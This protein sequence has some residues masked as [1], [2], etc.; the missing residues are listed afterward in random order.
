MAD[1]DQTT[2]PPPEET[3]AEDQA[4]ARSDADDELR[5]EGE[6]H[7]P[8][9]E[10]AL[11]SALKEEVERE[12]DAAFAD[13][14]ATETDPAAVAEPEAAATPAEAQS[15]PA[16]QAEPGEAAT[17]AE[18]ASPP[19]GQ[20]EPVEPE[21]AETPSPSAA[22]ADVDNQAATTGLAFDD[23]EA[24]DLEAKKVLM[25]EVSELEAAAERQEAQT[26]PEGEPAEGPAGEPAAETVAQAPA[27]EAVNED[28][29][30]EGESPAS[31]VS[32]EGQTPSEAAETAEASQPAEAEDQPSEQPADEETPQ[33]EEAPAGEGEKSPK[34][35]QAAI[36]AVAETEREALLEEQPAEGRKE[37]DDEKDSEEEGESAETEGGL[38]SLLLLPLQALVF[39]LGLMDR[40]FRGV[41]PDTRDLLGK[42][43]LACLVT[44]VLI[45]IFAL[46]RPLFS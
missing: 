45:F 28:Q 31:E 41:G 4:T 23:D 27:E 13:D 10:E 44:A 5:G 9:A 26:A 8:P 22:V 17:P 15:P 18:A 21:E 2:S 34:P 7:A 16:K 30:A 46:L 11:D 3:P 42:L 29:S 14:A 1:Q 36:D 25:E 40:P 39:L 6:P 43:G 24:S 38:G 35:S 20:A 32:A 12:V 37:A 33:P 19:A